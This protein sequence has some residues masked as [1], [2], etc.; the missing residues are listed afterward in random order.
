VQH[1]VYAYRLSGNFISR[2]AFWEG[3]GKAL[4]NKKFR[5]RN[6]K[7]NVLAT[8]RSLLKK[9]LFYRLPRTIKL[10]FSKPST[11]FRQ[12]GLI[13]TVLSCVAAGYIRF[14]LTN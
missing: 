2:R 8:E 7:V 4:L 6:N 5:S 14:H 11:G 10:V 3:Y 1:K 9:I 13:I 12:F